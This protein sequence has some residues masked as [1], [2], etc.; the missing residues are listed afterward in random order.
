MASNKYQ[1]EVRCIRLDG[2][3]NYELTWPDYGYIK[4]NEA[5]LLD[6]KPLVS[7]SS[8]KRRKDESKVI[9]RRLVRFDNT[10]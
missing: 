10:I 7:N 9:D 3:N 6:F 4:F 8:L 2:K 1:L 5:K